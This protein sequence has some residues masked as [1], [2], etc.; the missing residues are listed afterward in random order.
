MSYSLFSSSKNSPGVSRPMLRDTQGVD[1]VHL[2]KALRK[3]ANLNASL[4]T[5]S[6]FVI[7]LQTS[8]HPRVWTLTFTTSIGCLRGRNGQL[9]TITVR[10]HMRQHSCANRKYVSFRAG[11]CYSSA[12]AI[13]DAARSAQGGQAAAQLIAVVACE[14]IYASRAL[15]ATV[16]MRA[17]T[18]Q[19]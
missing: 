2:P 11:G 9:M 17:T 18:A 10:C 7:M 8:I 4:D 1:G 14:R 3:Q 19:F 13:C 6:T 16:L 15:A 12:S 5:V